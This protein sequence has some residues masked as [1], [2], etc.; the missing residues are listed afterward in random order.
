MIKHLYAGSTRP[1]LRT[2]DVFPVVEGEI[3]KRRPEIRL[4]FAGYTLPGSIMVC[5]V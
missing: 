4:L 1:S 5:S 2:A 3:E